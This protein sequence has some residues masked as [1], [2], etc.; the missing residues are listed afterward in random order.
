MMYTATVWKT[1]EMVAE[2]SAANEQEAQEKA[3]NM[4]EEDFCFF[5]AVDYD[6]KIERV[7]E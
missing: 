1:V 7:R 6:V 5:D 3:L 2:I 4:N